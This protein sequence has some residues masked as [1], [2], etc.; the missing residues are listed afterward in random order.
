MMRRK[1]FNEETARALRFCGSSM[2]REI[3]SQSERGS[4]PDP[5]LTVGVLLGSLTLALFAP[6]ALIAGGTPA[7][8][9]FACMVS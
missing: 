5:S 4:A 1:L 7:V 9:V 8:P 3:V 2:T 6:G